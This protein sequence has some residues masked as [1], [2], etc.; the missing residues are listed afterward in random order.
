MK[1]WIVSISIILIVIIIATAGIF[2][3][4]TPIGRGIWNS[5]QHTMQKVDDD[6]L[7]TTRKK[8]EDTC[9]SMMASYK[10]DALTWK[11]YKDAGGE[12]RGWADQAKMRA[13][14]TAAS[15]NE[16]VLKNSYVWEG[17]V[18]ADIDYQLAYI[19]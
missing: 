5:Y 11:Q 12:Q 17:N 7:Y 18:P 1:E 2:F 16:F 9:R 4:C 15:Y 10:A 6:T 3:G 19:E 13:N 14:K 8:V